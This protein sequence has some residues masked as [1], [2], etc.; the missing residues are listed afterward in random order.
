ML[1][2]HIPPNMLL[3]S[4]VASDAGELKETRSMLYQW[5][6]CTTSSSKMKKGDQDLSD[7]KNV[8]INH[9]HDKSEDPRL[10]STSL[11]ELLAQEGVISGKAE[12]IVSILNPRM[13]IRDN[14]K[15]IEQMTE[16]ELISEFTSRSA[17]HGA[18]DPSTAEARKLQS[19]F[20]SSCSMFMI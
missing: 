6:V 2:V 14:D 7:T 4:K 3:I 10:K 9:D 16:D 11:L 1:L 13:N 20:R 15:P 8:P 17:R 12:N 5:S 19:H 18:E